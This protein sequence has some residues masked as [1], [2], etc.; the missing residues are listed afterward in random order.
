MLEKKQQERYKFTFFVDENHIIHVNYDT[1]ANITLEDAQKEVAF[2]KKN[3]GGQKT[4]AVVNI[5]KVKSVD[6]KA[7]QLYA[8]PETGEVYKATA[9]IVNS[10]V[11]KML[12]NF[13][14]GL[15]KPKMPVKLFNSVEEGIKWLKGLE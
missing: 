5:T 14:L 4:L 9:L 11:S 15:N 13:F 3:S 2:V 7:R 10:P 8:G 6:Q 12:G 1:T